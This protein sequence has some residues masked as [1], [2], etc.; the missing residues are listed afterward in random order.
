[1]IDTPPLPCPPRVEIRFTTR[2]GGFSQPPFD[3]FNLGLHVG[4]DPE[5]VRKNRALLATH[6]PAPPHWLEQ[7]HTAQV[8]ELPNCNRQADASIA[9]T[10]EI[11]CAVLTADCLP[12]LLADGK[13]Q[14]VAAIHAGWRG[15]A[16]GIVEKTVEKMAI[17][18]TRL[19]AYLGPAIGLECY[20]V[21]EEMMASF[22]SE[23][24]AAFSKKNN[25]WHCDLFGLAEQ[26]LSNLGI[27]SIFSER[28]C[29]FCNPRFFSYRRDK[30]TG[31]MASLIWLAARKKNP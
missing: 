7:N 20:T 6:L 5:D 19:W 30:T 26:R 31:R 8:I 29:T 24:H 13:S 18:S 11:V 25:R 4:D 9:R 17:P 14:V 22:P 16:Q 23:D 10:P 27:T 15:L 1:M 2:L 21:G 3:G 28:L 12:I